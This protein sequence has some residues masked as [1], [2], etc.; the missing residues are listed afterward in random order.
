M[1]KI[2]MPYSKRGRQLGLALY[3]LT[4]NAGGFLNRESML[5]LGSGPPKSMLS[6]RGLRYSSSDVIGLLI[7]IGTP[8]FP[9]GSCAVSVNTTGL[10]YI[11]IL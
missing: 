8:R 7:S 9:L 4:R 1:L 6:S 3:G 10:R 2:D 5:R 11:F